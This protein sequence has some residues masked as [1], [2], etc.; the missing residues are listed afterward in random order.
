MVSK[1]NEVVIDADELFKGLTVRVK[2]SPQRKIRNIIGRLFIVTGAWVMGMG[3]EE[4]N[5]ES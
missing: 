5:D 3:Y 1:E 2:E 4:V